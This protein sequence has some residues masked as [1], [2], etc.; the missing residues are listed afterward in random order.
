MA[1]KKNPLASVPEVPARTAETVAKEYQALCQN[2]GDTQYKI[3]A[4]QN[5]LDG[6]NQQ[7][8]KLNQEHY[9]MMQEAQAQAKAQA[10]ADAAAGSSA[11]A[12][13]KS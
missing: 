7:M 1:K 10:L 12:P 5:D 4:L 3:V 11:P 9:K 8:L 13:A 2:A 6:M